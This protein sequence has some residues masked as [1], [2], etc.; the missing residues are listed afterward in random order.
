MQKCLSKE[1]VAQFRNEGYFFHVPLLSGAEVSEIRGHLEAFEAEQ[2]YPLEGGQRSHAH[3]LF[4]W[5]DSL[6]RYPKILDVVE[7][8]V[9]PDILCWGSIFWTKEARSAS[10]VSWH[11]DITYW[12]LTDGDVVNVWVALS[13]ANEISGCMSV[14]PGS[15]LQPPLP[16]DDRYH[17]DN[18]L[19]RGQEIAVDVDSS[20]TVQMPLQSGQMSLHDIR[21]AHGSGPNRSDERRIGFSVQYI[22]TCVRQAKSNEDYAALVRGEDH[23]GHFTLT[24]PPVHSMDADAVAIHER[25]SAATREILYQGA[26]QKTARL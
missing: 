9:G 3:L 19:T 17:E 13:T 21:I 10:F 25:A 6:V 23:Y 12:G 24:T 20:K 7:D 18:M 8:L 11:Q 2:G 26:E 5:L 1:A 14:L 16:H 15:H 4:P 22:P